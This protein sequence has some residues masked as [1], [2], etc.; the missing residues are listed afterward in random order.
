M[1]PELKY[2]NYTERLRKLGLT[3]LEARRQR[4]DLIQYFKFVNILQMNIIFAKNAFGGH[5]SEKNHH[6]VYVSKISH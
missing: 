3:T 2:L 6:I 5:Y 1:V 4:G